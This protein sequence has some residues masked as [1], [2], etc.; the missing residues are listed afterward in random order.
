MLDERFAFFASWFIAPAA[1][2][3][4]TAAAPPPAPEDAFAAAERLEE[5]ADV[6]RVVVF[7]LF[8]EAAE[9][10]EEF[11]DI[12]L[13]V[14]F[15]L[16]EEAAERLE[17]FADVARDAVFVF[18]V[19]VMENLF[20]VFEVDEV[21]AA[22][23]PEAA[24]ARKRGSS[25]TNSLSGSLSSFRCCAVAGGRLARSGRFTAGRADEISCIRCSIA[26][27]SYV[28]FAIKSPSP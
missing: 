15:V 14:V 20:P 23:V 18:R 17:E 3:P 21:A 4:A 2:P 28:P 25:G 13:V 7:V 16:F 27:S 5:F 11:A 22:C 26:D 8:A 10:L 6:V 9:R 19:E 1:P 12:V 24:E